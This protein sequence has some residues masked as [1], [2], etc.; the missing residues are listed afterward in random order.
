MSRITLK[1][2]LFSDCEG[3]LPSMVP[4]TDHITLFVNI[5]PQN[6]I[7]KAFEWKSFYNPQVESQPVESL[8]QKSS[9]FSSS[10][11]LKHEIIFMARTMV[12]G[13]SCLSVEKVLQ[14]FNADPRSTKSKPQPIILTMAHIISF[15]DRRVLKIIPQ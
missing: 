4:P 8:S 12:Y 6:K 13:P 5:R 15:V 1:K 11:N 9:Q 3:H 10:Q 7:S 2:L 14:L